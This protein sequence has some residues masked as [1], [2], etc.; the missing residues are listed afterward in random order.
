VSTSRRDAGRRVNVSW[1][2]RP[3]AHAGLHRH[4]KVTPLLVMLVS[5][6][7]LC[8]ECMKHT[9]YRERMSAC[10]VYEISERISLKFGDRFS[11]KICWKDL[12][13]YKSFQRKITFYLRLFLD[14]DYLELCLSIS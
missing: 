2:C 9:H 1:R 7:H 13:A 10:C 4:A 3:L 11:T 5:L 14:R 8:T 6:R 12:I